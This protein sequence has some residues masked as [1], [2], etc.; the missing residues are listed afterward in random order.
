MFTGR[1]VVVQLWAHALYSTVDDSSD[2]LESG[3]T[4]KKMTMQLFEPT[5][6]GAFPT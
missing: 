2:E 4:R 6:T 3:L 5:Y 1:L